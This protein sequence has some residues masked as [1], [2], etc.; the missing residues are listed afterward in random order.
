M[1]RRTRAFTLVE[2]L[3]VIGI[4]ALLIGILI[5]AL[6]KAQQAAQQQTCASNIRQLA[7][8]TQNFA[9]DNKGAYVPT[10][11][12]ADP[13]GSVDT[14]TINGV[15]VTGSASR[16]WFYCQIFDSSFNVY[17]THENSL[18]WRYLKTTAVYDCPT[19]K[20]L[21]LS[22]GLVPTAYGIG[23]V[24]VQKMNQVRVPAEMP[25]FGEV[26]NVASTGAMSYLDSGQFQSPSTV[27]SSALGGSFDRFHGRHGKGLGN[28]AFFDGHVEAITAQIRP[29]RCYNPIKPETNG[30]I[31]TMKAQKIGIAYPQRI[32][33]DQIPDYTTYRARTI[34][35][36]NYY[37]WVNKSTKS[38]Q[39]GK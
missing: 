19:I 38:T 35:T 18:L 22:Y 21:N 8:A 32:D 37:W 12:V 28:I 25:M 29:G 3:V 24:G 27:A 2:L 6:S 16:S 17:Y 4:I 11:P 34:D 36:F 33:F 20:S 23:L 10:G 15:S 30:G 9:A 14:V 31:L 5:P 26:I 1:D 13:T 39:W 7:M